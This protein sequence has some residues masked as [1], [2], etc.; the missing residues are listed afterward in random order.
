MKFEKKWIVLFVGFLLLNLY[1][2]KEKESEEI[3]EIKTTIDQGREYT[4][5]FYIS[6]IIF[7][8]NYCESIQD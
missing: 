8:E 1:G 2:C 6:S 3:I 7:I 5:M 4:E